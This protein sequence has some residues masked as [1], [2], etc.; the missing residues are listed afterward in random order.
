M[1]AWIG[2][3]ILVI[4]FIMALYGVGV[5]AYGALKRKPEYVESARR[6]MLLIWPL[7][8]VSSLALIWL[9][10][11]LGI[12]HGLDMRAIADVAYRFCDKHNLTYNSRAGRARLASEGVQ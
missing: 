1:I 11:G 10:N 12:E 4:A 2:Y 3:F 9:L 7:L 6:A 5:A 8:T